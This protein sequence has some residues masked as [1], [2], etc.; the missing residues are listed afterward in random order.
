MGNGE[1][2]GVGG[3]EL[4]YAGPLSTLCISLAYSLRLGFCGWVGFRFPSAGGAGF[5]GYQRLLP[6]ANFAGGPCSFHLHGFAVGWSNWEGCA[7]RADGAAL[8]FRVVGWGR[9]THCGLLRFERAP[10]V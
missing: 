1:R 9:C 3:S 6:Y 10:V 2:A 7:E 8:S 4:V 5:R